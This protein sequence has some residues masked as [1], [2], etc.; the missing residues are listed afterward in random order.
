GGHD[1]LRG[2]QTSLGVHANEIIIEKRGITPATALRL[3]AFFGNTP[4]FW[5]NLQQRWDLYHSAE[6]EMKNNY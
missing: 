6:F 1:S 3:A 2:I 5:M 4:D